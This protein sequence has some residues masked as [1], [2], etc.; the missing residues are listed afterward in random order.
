VNTPELVIDD[1]LSADGDLP[2]GWRDVLALA[3]SPYCSP[4]MRAIANN[5]LREL[6]DY[7]DSQAQYN[8]LPITPFHIGE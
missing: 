1:N 7:L 6:V 2:W 3:Q 4:D 8:D 5:Q